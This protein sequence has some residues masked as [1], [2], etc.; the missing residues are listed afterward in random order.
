MMYS[1]YST[2]LLNSIAEPQNCG[3]VPLAAVKRR[4]SAAPGLKLRHG[5]SLEVVQRLQWACSMYA[6]Q[7]AL[8][9]QDCVLFRSAR[10]SNLR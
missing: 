9:R 10:H 2:L 4:S 7:L 3:A 1:T 8:S 5:L 6:E